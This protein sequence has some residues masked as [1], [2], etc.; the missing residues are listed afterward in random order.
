MNWKEY[1]ISDNDVML[2]KPII[3]GTRLTIEFIIKLLASGWD[4]KQILENYP[5]LS[6][7]HLQALFSFI[8]ENM[9][10]KMFIN[11]TTK[12]VV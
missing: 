3:K 9:Q 4:E 8:L 11:T 12:I 1:I 2:G 6:K 7:V 5:Q 10:D